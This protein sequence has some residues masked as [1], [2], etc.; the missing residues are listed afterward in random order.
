ML[1][2]CRQPVSRDPNRQGTGELRLIYQCNVPVAPLN[3]PTTDDVIHP[4]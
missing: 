4:P 2:K 1:Q 3:G